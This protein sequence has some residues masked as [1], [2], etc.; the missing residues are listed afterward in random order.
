MSRFGKK[1]RRPGEFHID[2]S[3]GITFL[4]VIEVAVDV[5]MVGLTKEQQAR[6]RAAFKLF[7]LSEDEKAVLEGNL[8]RQN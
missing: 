6:N 4:D 1:L 7:E 8:D 5:E 3:L 2:A